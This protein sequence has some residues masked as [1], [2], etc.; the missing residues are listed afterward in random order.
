[1]NVLWRLEEN[2]NNLWV[3]ATFNIYIFVDVTKL[4]KL[5]KYKPIDILYWEIIEYQ[6]YFFI[7]LY[8]S[9]IYYCLK[10]MQHF[11]R[12]PSILPCIAVEKDTS[13]KKIGWMCMQKVSKITYFTSRFQL[14]T[15]KMTRVCLIII[16]TGLNIKIGTFQ[17]VY[18]WPSWF[19]A[20]MILQLGDHFEKRTDWSLIYFLNYAY[21]DI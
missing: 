3:L 16:W 21:F 12:H 1:M 5:Q 19:F 7:P 11:K 4:N 20:K 6:N 10:R 14:C 9:K 17:K 2:E 15:A 8:S 13:L 18:E